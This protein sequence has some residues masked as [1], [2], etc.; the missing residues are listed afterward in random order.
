MNNYPPGVNSFSFGAPWNDIEIEKE[1]EVILNCVISTTIPGPR[2]IT[3]V[4][5]EEIIESICRDRLK[6]IDVIDGIDYVDIVNV[7]VL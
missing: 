2:R 5:K 3:E 7:K 1:V 4:E 6:E